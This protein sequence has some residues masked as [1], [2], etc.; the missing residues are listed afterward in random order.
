MAVLALAVMIGVAALAIDVA[1]WY[2][3]HH[4]AQVA[5]DAAALAAASCLDQA[6][7]G[8]TC[9]DFTDTTHA[10]TVATT[11]A[12]TNG[13]PVSGSVSF[14]TTQYNV[15]V[16]TAAPAPLTFAGI[17][18]AHSVSAVAVSGW[19]VSNTNLSIFTGNQSC[20]SG[21]GL[22]IASS[23]GGNA[24]VNGLYAD[25]VIQNSDNSGSAG[26]GGTIYSVAGTAHCSST[27]SWNA[28]NT[29]VDPGNDLAYP[30]QFSEPTINASTITG[31]EPASAPAVTAGQC[32][33]AATYFSTD[34]TGI[35]Q[36][37][38][39]GVYCVIPSAGS[40]TLANTYTATSDCADGVNTGGS[41]HGKTTNSD[42]QPGSIYV[43]TA[44]SGG[45]EFAGPCVVANGGLSSNVTAI[46]GSPTVYGT[47]QVDPA[48]TESCLDPTTT[49]TNLVRTSP[50]SEVINYPD[51]VFLDGNN[52]TLNAPIYDPCGSVEL[53]GNSAYDAV[54][55]AANVFLDKNNF[56]S[57]KGT[58]PQ[59]GGG[60]AALLQ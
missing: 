60:G 57:F 18:F 53:Y 5:A 39:P 54:T 17:T 33:F 7:S 10:G 12:S 46:T 45:F 24:T 49:P 48:A 58:G 4:Q 9:T 59:I 2:Q 19:N 44:L 43:G 15:T 47:N 32:T 13:V 21:T 14:N 55:E 51:G 52:L 31:S 6:K 56:T 41:V 36:I 34:A 38:Y 25:G 11:Y 27:N 28:K 30:L 20:S 50:H 26:Y 40:T 16:T 3:K 42:D 22:Q 37:K 23:G 8:A 35:N 1:G 29:N